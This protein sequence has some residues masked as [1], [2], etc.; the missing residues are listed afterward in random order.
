MKAYTEGLHRACDPHTDAQPHPCADCK[1][2]KYPH[3]HGVHAVD[4]AQAVLRFRPAVN[5]TQKG[6]AHWQHTH[7]YV[8]VQRRKVG[9]HTA[10]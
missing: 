5:C 10:S 3:V 1:A 9:K 6:R 8:F 2:C 4:R 7:T